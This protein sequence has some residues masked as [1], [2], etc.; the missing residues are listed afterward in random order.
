MSKDSEY[1]AKPEPAPQR[2][3][4]PQYPDSG[5]GSV[6]TFGARLLA[7]LVDAVLA[8]VLAIVVNGGYHTSDRQN[9]SAYLA[10]LLIEIVFVTLASQ[11]P[12][13]RV[14]GVAVLKESDK[15][16]PFIGWIL[17]RTL[18][19]AVVAPALVIDTEGRAMSDRAAG[20]VMLRTR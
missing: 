20:T 17:L 13:M 15:T 6:A 3:P 19:I 10:F 5:P 12:G 18:L 4:Q 14:A 9:L 11:T 7:F 8:D 1:A 2:A 16:R